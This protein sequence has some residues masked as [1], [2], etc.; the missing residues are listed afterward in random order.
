LAVSIGAQLSPGYR[1]R[2]VA[3]LEAGIHIVNYKLYV[4]FYVDMQIPEFEF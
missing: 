3:L 2:G 4:F 1:V